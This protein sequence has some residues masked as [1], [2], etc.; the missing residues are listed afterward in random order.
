M[1]VVNNQRE[2]YIGSPKSHVPN[3]IEF[4]TFQLVHSLFF[5][6]SKIVYVSLR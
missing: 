2:N 6:E 4:K 5:I 3:A 1:V